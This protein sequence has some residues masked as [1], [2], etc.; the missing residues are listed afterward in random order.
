MLKI[1]FYVI[2]LGRNLFT[3]EGNRGGGQGSGLLGLHQHDG[4]GNRCAHIG[5]TLVLQ[6]HNLEE[7]PSTSARTLSAYL[8]EKNRGCEPW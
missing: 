8:V 1:F 7:F 2:I 4:C 5:H 6:I 3:S